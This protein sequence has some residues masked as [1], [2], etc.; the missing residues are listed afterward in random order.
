ML[1]PKSKG[2]EILDTIAESM[3]SGELK[4]F[5]I[6]VM[7]IKRDIDKLANIALK[8]HLKGIIT[9]LQGV[10]ID[11]GISLCERAIKLDPTEPSYWNNYIVTL[12]NAGLHQKHN[13]FIEESSYL[14]NYHPKMLGYE[15]F[16]LGVYSLRIELIDAAV[17]ILEK[18]GISIDDAGIN[19]ENEGAVMQMRNNPELI[20]RF[21]PMVDCLFDVV[22]RQCKGG[23]STTL[24]SDID[25]SMTY[26]FKVYL[27][28][29]EISALNDQLFDLLYEKDLLSSDCCIYIEPRGE[30]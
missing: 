3:L 12:R 21:R 28:M 30:R 9:I 7:G 6:Q 2:R 10:E 19:D 5:P 25:G 20:E 18:M 8:L 11:E 27:D 29:D 23:I 26:V 16:M 1:S 13:A 14:I 15:L 4:L 24:K 22:D 17:S